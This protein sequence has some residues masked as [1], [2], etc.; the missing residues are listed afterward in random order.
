MWQKARGP[1]RALTHRI[2]ISILRHRIGFF[3]WYGVLLGM[4]SAKEKLTMMLQS[5]S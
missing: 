4:H 5:L 1:S 2:G 3:G